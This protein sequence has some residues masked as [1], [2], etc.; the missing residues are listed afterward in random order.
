M[1]LSLRRLREW[2][3]AVR[4]AGRKVSWWVMLRALWSGRVPRA[5][6]RQRMRVCLRCPV[7]RAGLI[8]GDG[9]TLG[10][11]CYTPFLAMTAQPYEKGCWVRQ[12]GVLTEGWGPYWKP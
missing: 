8:C 1:P 3:A 11:S 2:R 5:V 6:W 12:V 10:C 7:L 9:Q 4:A